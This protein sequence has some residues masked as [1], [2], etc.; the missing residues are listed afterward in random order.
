MATQWSVTGYSRSQ[1]PRAAVFD[2]DGLL[3]DSAACWRRAYSAVAV[4]DVDLDALAGASVA[5]A[6][7]FLGVS[8]DA[9][10]AALLSAVVSLPPPPLPGAHELIAAL[11]DCLPLA[12][13]SNAP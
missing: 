3:V 1:W 9:L 12:V 6:A 10:R 11:R 4:A 13:A 8:E 7:T 5:G 2:C